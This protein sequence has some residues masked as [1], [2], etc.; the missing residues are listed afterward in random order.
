MNKS[1]IK[2]Y[3]ILILVFSTGLFLA[4]GAGTFNPNKWTVKSIAENIKYEMRTEWKSLG[5]KE[6]SIE[7]NNN[8]EFVR[9]V[10]RCIQWVNFNLDPEKRIPR[11]IILSM[12]VLETGYGKSRFALEGNNLFGIRTWSKDVPQLKAKGNPD[13]VWGV[14]AYPTKCASV[15]DMIDIINRHPAYEGFRIARE[16]QFFNNS[17]NLELLVDELHKW[18]T[19]PEYVTLVKSKIKRVNDI[20]DDTTRDL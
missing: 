20:L 15:I 6:P 14:K 3:A 8:N 10:N 12:A 7:Y 5:L 18:S 17:I 19:N 9:S 13:A 1:K 16:E 4:Y 2:I 11:E